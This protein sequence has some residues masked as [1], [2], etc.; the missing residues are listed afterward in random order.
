MLAVGRFRR[1]VGLVVLGVGG[2]VYFVSRADL[3]HAQGLLIVA[4]AAAAF[5]R[6][7]LVGG[8]FLA[9]LIPVGT[10]NRA[11]RC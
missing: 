1:A 11:W 5:V 2:A 8:V 3:E 6:P 7:R 4:A 9:L 10:A